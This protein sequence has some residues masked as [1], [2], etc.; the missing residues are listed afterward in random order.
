MGGTNYCQQRGNS[1]TEED[2]Y[3]DRLIGGDAESIVLLRI[4]PHRNA[5]LQ[6]RFEEAF[7]FLFYERARTEKSK[8]PPVEENEKVKTRNKERTFAERP[9][10]STNARRTIALSLFVLYLRSGCDG[11]ISFIGE[12][13]R[14][15]KQTPCT[16]FMSKTRA[17]VGVD[18]VRRFPTQHKLFTSPSP[19]RRVL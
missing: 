16:W 7:R 1:E 17:R 8:G 3:L 19:S 5:R 4:F 15:I 12:G 6:F 9:Y 11:L 14:S 13:E 2:H 18:H 10:L